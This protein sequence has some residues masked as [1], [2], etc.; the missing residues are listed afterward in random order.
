MFFISGIKIGKTVR[1]SMLDNET[2]T[3]VMK[4]FKISNADIVI[5]SDIS[6]DELIDCIE[7]N[8]KYVPAITVLN[9][10]DMVSPAKA[11]E[12]AKKV[13]ADLL[14]SG[15]DK[16]S[17][18]ELKKLI[19]DRLNLIRIYMKEP[20][21]DADMNIPLIIFR[22]STIEDVCSKLHKDFVKKFKFARVW[23]K[24]AKFP[25]QKLSLKHTMK[26]K[27]ILEIHLT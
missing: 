5:R 8:K 21:K 24:S 3:A 1:L 22:N 23:G 20:G 11:R 18:E 2:I 19:F 17:L 9:K 14:I 16:N 15:K 27:D 4:E 13:H 12:I 25:G 10:I 7:D 6:V 26:D